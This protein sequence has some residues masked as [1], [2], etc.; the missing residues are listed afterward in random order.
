MRYKNHTMFMFTKACSVLFPKLLTLEFTM[1]LDIE[2]FSV[3]VNI[4]DLLLRLIDSKH[5]LNSQLTKNIKK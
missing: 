5:Q 1:Q 2:A 3:F 4:E